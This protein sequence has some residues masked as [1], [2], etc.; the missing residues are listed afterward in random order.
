MSLAVS[1][2]Q[3]SHSPTKNDLFYPDY[4]GFDG[5]R[6]QSMQLDLAGNE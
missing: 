3:K 1:L 4:L 5:L 6:I 2:K